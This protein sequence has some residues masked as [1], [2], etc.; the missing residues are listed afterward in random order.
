M[1]LK[2]SYALITGGAKRIGEQIAKALAD[3]GCHLIL[4]YNESRS[5]V[6]N[7]AKVLQKKVKVEVVSCDFSASEE[8]SVEARV[9]RFSREVFE[10]VPRVDILINN[11]AIFYPARFEKITEKDWD[12]FLTINLKFPFFLAKTFGLKMKKQKRGKIINIADWTAS[13]P[14]KNFLPYAISKA[15]IVCLTQALAK[16]LAP[17]VQ[18]NAVSPGPILPPKGASVVQI[19]KKAKETLAQRCGSPEDISKTV[20]YL[21]G[22]TD[23]VTGAVI[24]VEGGALLV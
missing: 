21:C 17:E 23:F 1:K 2:G 16:E 9:E 19:K 20:L 12:S 22:E 24:P 11:A 4:H 6:R 8:E 5:E 13:R 15:G 14:Q 18:V 3:Q 7:L 10:K